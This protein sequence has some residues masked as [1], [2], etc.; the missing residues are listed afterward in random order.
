MSSPMR[1][2]RSS[3]SSCSRNAWRTA[4]RIVVSG[5]GHLRNR[6]GPTLTPTLSLCRGEGAARRRDR[7]FAPIAV[8]L[9][10]ARNSAAHE[11][12]VAVDVL[13]EALES[14]LLGLF[15]EANRC[16]HLLVRLLLDT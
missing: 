12:G 10:L 5:I 16:F 6:G 9:T 14:W 7:S 13:V 4:S 3:A 1:K 11:V 15:C 8:S 2:T